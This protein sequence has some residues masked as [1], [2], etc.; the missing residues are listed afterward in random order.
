MAN[1][2]LDVGFL[3]GAVEGLFDRRTAPKR[4]LAW[5]VWTPDGLVV[6]FESEYEQIARM[7]VVLLASHLNSRPILLESPDGAE[8]YYVEGR[9]QAADCWYEP[10][11][12]VCGRSSRHPFS[13]STIVSSGSRSST[14]WCWPREAGAWRVIAFNRPCCAVEHSYAPCCL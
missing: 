11:R 3:A 5:R 9:W 14:C 1:A 8:S 12:G 7:L 4:R 6:L 2:D 10:R 13:E